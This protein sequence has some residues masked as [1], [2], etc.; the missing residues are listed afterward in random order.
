MFTYGG[1]PGEIMDTSAFAGG[2]VLG[3]PAFWPML[4]YGALVG[5]I[6]YGS[7]TKI[8]KMLRMPDAADKLY[9]DV[10]QLPLPTNAQTNFNYNMMFGAEFSG[11]DTLPREFNIIPAHHHFSDVYLTTSPL[12]QDWDG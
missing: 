7:E 12:P 1:V 11:E 3:W 2:N 10:L 5:D 8:A 4:L 6:V 9:S